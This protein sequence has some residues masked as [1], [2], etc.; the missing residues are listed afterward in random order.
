MNVSLKNLHNYW[1]GLCKRMRVGFPVE[2][3][4]C[5]GAEGILRTPV[6]AEFNE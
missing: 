4:A 2:R 1:V 5:A 3:G 6:Y